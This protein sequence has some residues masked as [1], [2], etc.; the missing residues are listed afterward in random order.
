MGIQ[1]TNLLAS[2]FREQFFPDL[3]AK[4]ITLDRVIKEM[5]KVEAGIHREKYGWRTGQLENGKIAGCFSDSAEHAAFDLAVW[6]GSPVVWI[7]DDPDCVVHGRY[8]ARLR[9]QD[10]PDARFPVT[11]GPVNDPVPIPVSVQVKPDEY[12][13]LSLF[14]F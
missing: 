2:K 3:R 11:D 12:G 7:V 9:R 8:E 6:W 10:W 13:Q 5:H 14:D 1:Y 4:K